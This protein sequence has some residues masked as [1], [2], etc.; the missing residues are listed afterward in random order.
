MSA[1]VLTRDEEQEL[2]ARVRKGD[3][4]A[5]DE[6][7]ARNQ[8]LVRMIARRH[9]GRG[10]DEDDLAQEGNAGLLRAIEKFDASRGVKF[11]T[12]AFNW[13]RQGVT[14]AIQEKA[15]AV[16]VPLHV[17]SQA[18]YWRRKA[19]E[20]EAKLGRAPSPDEVAKAL[21]APGASA[22]TMVPALVALRGA[23][24][25]DA[26]MGAGDDS[27]SRLDTVAAPEDDEEDAEDA[28]RKAL[29]REHAERLLAALPERERRVLEARF[30]LAGQAPLGLA[31]TGRGLALSRERVRQLEVRALKRIARREGLDAP[32]FK[33][34]GS[35]RR[36]LVAQ[37]YEPESRSA[38]EEREPEDEE[39]VNVTTTVKPHTNGTTQAPAATTKKTC[40][41]DGCAG[42]YFQGRGLCPKHYMRATSLVKK[43]L[44]SWATLSGA[45]W[46]A[47]GSHWQPEVTPAP[48]PAQVAK[49]APPS[50]AKPPKVAAVAPVIET[51]P[52]A[53]EPDGSILALVTCVEALRP[54]TPKMRA[55]ALS[56]LAERF[57][58][59][60]ER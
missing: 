31:E 46:K 10:L 35:A 16:Y 2:F 42:T 55:L 4:T 28:A 8:G 11:S 60:P 15:R 57:A 45:G 18:N 43:G 59:A 44:A 53:R 22:R 41:V 20:L 25:L 54:L 48:K 21:D 50:R 5:R 1:S 56:F 12:Y 30:G 52:P 14:R 23:M 51:E 47:I 34:T 29:A 3:L 36:A 32:A 38:L 19:V 33:S 17:Y 58:D 6:L 9:R 24:S 40:A 7:V 39:D 13:I 27:R 26:P 37:G 49:V